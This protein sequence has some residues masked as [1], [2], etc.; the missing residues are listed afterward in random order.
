MAASA[1][2]A[3]T[4]GGSANGSTVTDTTIVASPPF[5]A[6]AAVNRRSAPVPAAGTRTMSRGTRTLIRNDPLL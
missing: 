1:S 6:S 3:V 4:S 2:P 5:L